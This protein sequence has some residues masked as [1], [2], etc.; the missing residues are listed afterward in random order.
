MTH[1]AKGVKLL[2]VLFL[3]LLMQT[4]NAQS[5]ID[6]TD[7]VVNYDSLHPPPIPNDGQIT[8]WVRTPNDAVNNPDPKIGRNPGWNTDV[9][10][11]YIFQKLA[12]RVEFPKS[13]NP[14]A[15]DGK[16]YPIIIFL[17]GKG[18]NAVPP[19]YD[20]KTGLNYDNEWQLLQGPHEFDQAI[21]NGTYDGYVI[22]PQVAD[23]WWKGLRLAPLME[24]VKY[25]I[26]NNKVDPF[27]II[28]N[29]L[30]DGGTACW[31]MLDMFPNYLCASTPMS[32]PVKNLP[33]DSAYISSKR[34]TPIWVAQG[35]LDTG[36]TPQE[37]A[38]V[39]DSMLKYGSNFKESLYPELEHRTWYRFWSEPGFWPFVNLAYS[40]NP[41]M[42]GGL[43][44]PWPGAPFRDTIGIAPPGSGVFDDGH[45]FTG[46]LW[47][48]NGSEIT[49][50]TS[51]TLAVTSAGI[52]DAMVQRDGIWSDWSHV[53]IVIRP[54]F[55]QA[56]DFVAS[57]GDGQAFVR[58]DSTPDEG[59]GIYVG[60]IANGN[61]MDYTINP[62]VAGTF[63]LQVRVAAQ[64][65]GG[66]IQVR[67][68]DSSILATIDVPETGSWQ[69]FVTTQPVNITLP[70]GVQNIRLQ[71]IT[72]AG[73]NI[74]WL[75]FGLTGLQSP[76]P[77]K[78]VYFNSQCSGSAVNLQWKTAQEF[79]SKSFDVQRSV[80][81]LNWNSLSS[82]AAAGQSSSERTYH[83]SDNSS[84]GSS[85]Y[86]IVENDQDGRSVMSSV[87]RSNCQ[88]GRDVLMV[89]PNPVS[90]SAVLSI[91]LQQAATVQ[92]KII[93]SKGA[94]VQQNQ[95][96]LPSGSSSIPLNLSNYSKG[97][98]TISIYYNNEMKTIKL[99]KK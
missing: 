44:N 29:G 95:M 80:D 46:Y 33:M 37:T 65:G 15:N 38:N 23:Q 47:R 62:N 39:A 36:P 8:K 48:W 68:Q 84:S 19:L 13:Y 26:A 98:Y 27:H 24:V 87:V 85:F 66:K 96:V 43:R 21:Q 89:S 18:E 35:G 16:K 53:P 90:N 91:H 5:I 74:N 52:Y 55:Y 76:L 14:T 51:N 4:T 59:G 70:A 12:F 78:F 31:D 94:M 11:A 40:S 45:T 9:Y 57:N 49:G 67:G 6:P 71:S 83:Y 32:G 20:V 73:W 75:Q 69:N 34:F 60:W 50:Q 30:S 10:K 92:W 58:K 17:H 22:A 64:V 88:S 99:I 56:E 42:L 61:Y 2:P 1:L 25:M 54:G 41:W 28:V 86:R 97:V 79:N 3:S 72:N 82:I 81:G 77:V 63:T 7:Q 93:D